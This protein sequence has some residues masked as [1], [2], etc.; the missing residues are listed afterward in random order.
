MAH[1]NRADTIKKD[2]QTPKPT[3]AKHINYIELK[4]ENESK[5]GRK[6]T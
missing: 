3:N 6:S 5:D 1:S 4:V 2:R